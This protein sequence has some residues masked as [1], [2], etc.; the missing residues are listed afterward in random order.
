MLVTASDMLGKTQHIMVWKFYVRPVCILFSKTHK[1]F[2][3]NSEGVANSLYLVALSN[4]SCMQ[5]I[6]INSLFTFILLK[7]FSNFPYYGFSDIQSSFKSGNLISKYME[8]GA[9]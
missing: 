7:A 4:I 6:L 2:P 3:G 1:C 5:Q 9:F 8:F